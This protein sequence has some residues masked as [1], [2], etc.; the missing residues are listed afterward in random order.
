M[1][2][3]YRGVLLVVSVWEIFGGGGIGGGI[4]VGGILVEEMVGSEG[5]GGVAM[6][7]FS[8]G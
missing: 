8:L 7:L 5:Y 4:R 3:L 6:G 1:K 2:N